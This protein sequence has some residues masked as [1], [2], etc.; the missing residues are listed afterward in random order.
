MLNDPS[1]IDN[2][3]IDNDKLFQFEMQPHNDFDSSLVNETYSKVYETSSAGR[4]LQTRQTLL[5]FS[6]NDD[7]SIYDYTNSF[8]VFRQLFRST[9]VVPPDYVT[10]G[11]V[12]DD[13]RLAWA[14]INGTEKQI[15]R[16]V[17]TSAGGSA[18]DSYQNDAHI[19]YLVK[20]WVR[21][22]DDERRNCFKIGENDTSG[23]LP[24]FYG[25][26]ETNLVPLMSQ[27]IG[28]LAH[29]NSQIALANV[30]GIVSWLTN[31]NKLLYKQRTNV[32]PSGNPNE[33]LVESMIPLSVLFPY[34][35]NVEN[36]HTRLTFNIEL[37]LHSHT[38]SLRH[39]VYE[40][41]VDD[42][43][44]ASPIAD[45]HR[46]QW[47]WAS[48][49]PCFIMLRRVLPSARLFDEVKSAVLRGIVLDK[50]Y[51]DTQVFKSSYINTSTQEN[52]RVSNLL[53]RISKVIVFL[54]RQIRQESKV[55]AAERTW[56][57]HVADHLGMMNISLSVGG[58]VYPNNG[59]Y[60]PNFPLNPTETGTSPDI[61][62]E[63][64]RIYND[65]RRTTGSTLTY[66]DWLRNP[67]YCFDV[68][69]SD[70]ETTLNNELTLRWEKIQ[71]VGVEDRYNVYCVVEYLKNV[72]IE[73]NNTG[74][75][76]RV[77]S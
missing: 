46:P 48:S 70:R 56:N 18:I 35:K 16:A 76:V 49:N 74:S 43:G 58:V 22:E 24:K 65:W 73:M 50:S 44:H 53:G 42:A 38:S 62:A 5:Q 12:T 32:R 2:G 8:V 28:G 71:G 26:A 61:Q 19:S 3:V 30:G 25:S 10:N 66:S 21:N 29:A 72:H 40:E 23:L 60:E 47:D 20:D 1:T 45:A 7:A 75:L 9:G 31:V 33:F 55:L 15:R 11:W 17:L 69:S 41:G 34:F 27:N 14:P 39:M 36:A 4:A 52:W 64:L 51:P 57:P 13:E 68:R 54:Q 37:E 67:V 77:V 6:L 63:R 59:R